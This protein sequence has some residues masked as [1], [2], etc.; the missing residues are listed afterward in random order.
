MNKQASRIKRLP[1]VI[2]SAKLKQASQIRRSPLVITSAKLKQASQ[3]K[4]SPLVVRRTR[5]LLGNINTLCCG[6]ENSRHAGW[7]ITRHSGEAP[8]GDSQ[9]N[10][11]GDEVQSRNKLDRSGQPRLESDEA[12]LTRCSLC[13]QMGKGKLKQ[14]LPTRDKLSG[15]SKE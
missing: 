13:P 10:I 7:I 8:N 14:N 3:I 12:E 5:I 4:R 2:A 9:A 11:A 6:E 1:L 15:D